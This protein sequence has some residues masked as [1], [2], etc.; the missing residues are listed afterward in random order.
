MS[1]KIYRKQSQMEKLFEKRMKSFVLQMIAG[2]LIVFLFAGCAAVGPDYIQPEISTP[3]QWRADLN[4][5]LTQ[6]SM[7]A[8][9][10]ANWWTTL[11]DQMLTNLI[12][13]AVK[14]N[15][16]LKEAR[17][18]IRE[19]RAKRGISA[20]ERFP[21]L[22][23]SGSAKS[24]YSGEN[25]GSGE[26]GELYAAGFDANWELDL[27]GGVRRSIEAAQADLETSQEDY[28]D[29]MV[30]LLAE[31]ALNYVEVRTSQTRLEVAK[32]NLKAQTETYEL[33]VFRFE[34][35]L[36]TALDMEQAKYNLESTRSQIPTLRVSLEEAKNRLAV[37]LGI[38]PG[39]LQADLSVKKPIPVPPLEIAVGVPAQV[40]RRRPD[41]R[42]AERELAAQTARVG[43]ATAEL[44]PKFSLLGSI[45]LEA[46]SFP[47]LFSTGNRTDSIGAGFSWNIFDAGVI[48]KNIEVQNA[49][50]EQALIQ[51]EAA[52]LT[53]L[54]DVENALV[55]YSQDQ[56]RR[57]SLIQATQAAERAVDL[58][59][60]Q[61]ASGMIDFR[62]VLEA[63]RSLLSFQDQL[64]ESDGAATSNLITLYKAFG[65]GWTSLMPE[66]ALSKGKK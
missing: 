4:A 50:Q 51:Y 64:A 34:A 49:L 17:S 16:D 10:M 41:I 25:I 9:M 26:R 66:K 12:Q 45:G 32:E 29:V 48:R 21:T 43:V 62:D 31:V 15:L 2:M 65:G 52:I 54:E 61:Y 22:D 35:G 42:R 18:R 56:L 14:G 27:F 30:S 3:E 13:R 6:G 53:A 8:K 5:G 46:L 40:L 59:L 7:D 20:A 58:A 60:K 44:Y 33:T 23:V 1:K 39:A 19:A 36:A 24:S 57:Q 55:A 47:D 37:L 38:H 11:N 63:Q 28:R